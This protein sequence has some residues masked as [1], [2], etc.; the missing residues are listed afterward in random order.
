M[1]DPRFDI[2]FEPQKI[3]PVTAKNRF[4]QVPH[5]TGMGW[6]L[7]NAVGK[8]RGVKAEGGWAVVNT[9][10]CS[11]HPSSD[12]LL[13]PYASLWDDTDVR[14]HRIMTEK[15]YEHGALAGAELWY[16]GAGASNLYT[17]DV[18]FD[19]NAQPYWKGHPYQSR[20][21]DSQDFRDLRQ[22]YRDAALRAK[23]AGFDIIYAY[24]NHDYLLHNFQR[25]ATNDRTDQYGGSVRNRS[26]LLRETIEVL[27]EAVGETMA[28]AVR[29]SPD[30][31]EMKDGVPVVDEA[32]EFFAEVA[33]LP[34]LWD[35][36]SYSWAL[37]LGTSRYVSEGALEPGISYVKE[38]TSK[39]VVCQRRSKTPPLAGANMYH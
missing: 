28:V 31:D 21:M 20:K 7:P 10:Y 8:M 4:Y 35:L 22:W 2:L 27:K 32:R 17:R 13:S 34:D 14:A 39:P 11:I 30:D 1:R 36:T 6:Q 23:E 37:E 5:C 9:E 25:A 15:V 3:G 18:T 19:V 16:G 12:D 24:A 29:F 33:E 38:M 26:R